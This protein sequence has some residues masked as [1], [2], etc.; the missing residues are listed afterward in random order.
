MKF[1]KSW[2][3]GKGVREIQLRIDHCRS[4]IAEVHQAL[5]M[6]DV[7]LEIA[8]QFRRLEE[9]LNQVD[10]TKL[11]HRDLE[12]IEIATNRLLDEFRGL[13]RGRKLKNIHDGPVH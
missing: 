3:T 1:L 10:A 4:T 7:Q 2:V 8:E 12:K 5:S 13:Y 6:D 9:A 11:N